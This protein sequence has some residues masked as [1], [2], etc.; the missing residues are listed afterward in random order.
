MTAELQSAL[1][2]LVY[3]SIVYVYVKALLA[4]W[5]FFLSN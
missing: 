4:V 5:G 3:A 1:V 2:S